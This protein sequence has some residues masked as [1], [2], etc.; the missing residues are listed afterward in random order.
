MAADSRDKQRIQAA[1]P[2]Y[3]IGQELGRGAFG[4]VYQARH[5][6]LGR[7][8]AVKQLGQA[9]ATDEMV[10]Q[11]FVA[12]AQMVASLDHPHIVPVYDFIDQADGL[13]LI[14][15]ERCA[16]A[17]SDRFMSDG[18]ATDNACASV[19]ACLAALDF[20]HRAGVLHRDIKPEN[21]LFDA[22]GV[23]KLGDFGIA[24]AIDTNARRT[25]TGTV[26]GTPAYMSP[27]QVRGE[28]LTPA[29]DLYSVGIMAY[30][31]LT[32]RFPFSESQ[33]AT[34]LLAHHL[35][36]PPTPLT[37]TRPEL[38]AELGAVI[39]RTL[40]KEALDRYQSAL[41]LAA[42]LTRAGVAAFGTG[43]L[44]QGDHILHWPEVIAESER[45]AG[46]APRN[47]TIMVRADE[48]RTLLAGA[49][50]G[51]GAPSTGPNP[52]AGVPSGP[53]PLGT[54]PHGAPAHGIAP[55]SPPPGAFPGG[56]P[57]Q[58]QPAGTPSASYVPPTRQAPPAQHP[59]PGQVPTSAAP[60]AQ[61]PQARA[62]QG[63]GG[64]SSPPGPAPQ[65]G[66]GFTGQGAPTS[67][68]PAPFHGAAAS[69]QH[70]GFYNPGGPGS[71]GYNTGGLGS[72]GYGV[73]GSA[74]VTDK[75]RSP[76]L[77]VALGLGGVLVAALIV[78]A[79][80]G[81]LAGDDNG[82]DAAGDDVI[83]GGSTS[84]DETGADDVATEETTAN[85]AFQIPI[86]PVP[87]IAPVVVADTAWTPTPCP[88]DQERIACLTGV[89]IDSDSGEM[90]AAYQ[91]YG[92][93]P[94]LDPI[95]YHLH[96]YLDTVVGGD[97]R[98][99]GSEVSGGDWRSWDGILPFT[100]VDAESGRTGFRQADVE[101]TGARNLC[102]L[103]AD[104]DLRAVP[105]SGN[106][107]PIP[108]TFDDTVAL[109]Q[110]G[111]LQGTYAGSCGIGVTM[112]I[113]E[114]WR[115]VD[116]VAN[117]AADAARILR[118]GDVELATTYLSDFIASGGIL[119]VDGPLDGDFIVN[120]SVQR[121][122]GNY[123][124]ASTP[125]EV[126]AELERSGLY[127]EGKVTEKTFNG[128]T[129]NTQIVA[130]DGFELNQYVIPDFG[131]TMVVSLTAPQVADW[132]ETSDAMAA[133]VMGC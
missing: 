77:L 8:V 97:E 2:A 51:P 22:K 54:P 76:V 21:L 25:A 50:G 87:D 48:S 73:A 3:E 81:A 10:R 40:V 65:P 105:G 57:P 122:E 27:E 93:I 112:I 117:D 132:F 44:R 58:S 123:T 69:G 96:F 113:P 33:S 30:E 1:L 74:P 71:G 16:G 41:E 111:R 94:E 4:I 15:M 49:R 13:C 20:A 72:G 55:G 101:A 99:A 6:S 119:W 118:P 110:V 11:R 26:I 29:S 5:T 66:S 47:A 35:V 14:I 104:P 46:S 127:F 86:T 56:P 53:T 34:G 91:V 59:P 28:E 45:S 84:T 78:L 7:Q 95:D 89:A 100:S 24:R 92:F 80:I 52:P 9:F 12:E 107:A 43:W 116:L 79:V 103:V 120:L 121:I 32:G 83:A 38:P 131:Y 75:G 36:T 18:L 130:G 68:G 37:E 19:L 128:R 63:S 64:L 82:D 42:D 109:E 124:T 133:T 70:P 126:T 88:V 90:V 106:C 98:K 85:T 67:S 62:T 23:I 125:D 115:W 60:Q 31:L 114:D 61:A 102:V 39:D 108:Y 17:V 129:I